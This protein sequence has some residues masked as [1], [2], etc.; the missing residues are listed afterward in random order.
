MIIGLNPNMAF[1]SLNLQ[2]FLPLK[3]FPFM[4]SLNSLFLMGVRPPLGGS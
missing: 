2:L 3:P 1:Q 4:N